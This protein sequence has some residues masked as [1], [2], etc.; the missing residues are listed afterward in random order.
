MLNPDSRQICEIAS[1]SKCRSSFISRPVNPAS[2]WPD[3]AGFSQPDW[4]NV[5]ASSAPLAKLHHAA[6][7]VD[8]ED[9]HVPGSVV[10]INTCLT[11]Q[12][13][14]DNP[15]AYGASAVDPER[16]PL[17]ITEE[18]GTLVGRKQVDV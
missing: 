18:D 16:R 13:R 7:D 3:E 14:L 12:P 15:I 2:R 10:S 17:S 8:R 11:S 4:S 6:T 1:A 5:G 9:N